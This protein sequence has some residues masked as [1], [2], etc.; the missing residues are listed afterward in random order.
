MKY[1]LRKIFNTSDMPKDIWDY[2]RA[3]GWITVD[4]WHDWAIGSF[5]D[6]IKREPDEYEEGE[7]ANAE[8]IDQY[9]LAGGGEPGETILIEH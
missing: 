6:E 5:A 9:F 4:G 8:K 2:L 7:L 1:K 3:G